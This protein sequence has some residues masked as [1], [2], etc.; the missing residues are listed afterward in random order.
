MKGGRNKVIDWGIEYGIGASVSISAVY[1]L[2]L[3]RL[4]PGLV[5]SS[6]RVEQ[7]SFLS[8]EKPTIPPE[9]SDKKQAS[10]TKSFRTRFSKNSLNST[11]AKDQDPMS[12]LLKRPTL[13]MPQEQSHFLLAL[14][15][16]FS[17]CLGSKDRY[18][19]TSVPH[20]ST[21]KEDF[22]VWHKRLG[23]LGTKYLTGPN[24]NSS[25]YRYS[26]TLNG[27]EKEKRLARYGNNL[28]R[29]GP[30]P[31][32]PPLAPPLAASK[33]GLALLTRLG[34]QRSAEKG[35]TILAQIGSAG[36]V[37]ITCKLGVSLEIDCA[38]VAERYKGL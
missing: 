22:R 28:T 24:S 3:E 29:C 23:K 9:V 10:S 35:N 12:L 2:P 16:M 37:W 6:V 26:F 19:S 27:R 21:S 7:S 31:R 17:M 34:L 36:T 8:D 33:E 20:P 11:L 4:A 25:L 18:A 15:P 1:S 30:L 38:L 32:G 13:P 5:S 14:F